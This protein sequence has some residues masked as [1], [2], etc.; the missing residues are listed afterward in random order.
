MDR[1]VWVMFTYRK[2]I[3]TIFFAF[4]VLMG[5]NALKLRMDSGFEK[6]MP[7]QHDYIKTLMAYQDDFGSGN[8]IIVALLQ[9]EGDIFTPAFFKA[10]Q[11]AT[12]EIFFLP[13]VA[14]SSVTSLFTPNVIYIEV[15]EDG[16]AGGNVIPAE[17]QPT[18]EWMPVV[19]ANV[20]KSGRLG[21]LVAN[22][23]SGALIR[24]ELIERDPTTGA[25][26]DYRK[27]AE[28]LEEKIRGRF[29]GNG[30]DVSIIGFAKS[31]GDI[32]KGAGDVVIFFGI[33]LVITGI[34]LW[35]YTRSFVLSLLP[36]LVSLV[37]VIGLLG[38]L[39]LLG[40]GLDP[41]SIL[42]PFLVF[43][44]GVSH[45]VQMVSGWMGE[46]MYG[47]DA[48][49]HGQPVVPALERPRGV[50]AMEAAQRTFRRLLVPGA[51]AVITTSVSFATILLIDIQ[52][53]RETAITASVGMAIML[54]T[55][56]ILLP[57]LL[58]YVRIH[59][60][61]A[62]RERHRS[63]EMRRDALWRFLARATDTGPSLA[64]LA[65][66]TLIALWGFHEGKQMK[67]G[68]LHAGIPELR[69]NARYNIDSR[70]IED[71]F[72]I[73]VDKLSVIVEAPEN[74]C[75]DYDIMKEIDRF[76]WYLQGL[77][78]V[79]SVDSLAR[80]IK[81]I[82]AANNEGNPRWFDLSR[83][84]NNQASALHDLER[85]GGD[86]Y[87]NASCSAM[88]VNIY[89]VDHK[90][91]TIDA[92]IKG[93]QQFESRLPEEKF[94]LR[95]AAGNVGI[96]GATNQTVAAAERPMLGWVYG[97]TIVLALLAFRSV[98]GTLCIVIP[99]AVVSVLGNAMMALLGIGLKVNTLPMMALGVG[100][101]V[102]Y[103]IY[104]YSAMSG[105]V[106]AGDTLREAYY[107]A[108]RLTGKAVIFI[109]MT[110]GAGVA[111]WIFAS[112]KFQEDMGIL[113]T[114][115]FLTNMLGAILILPALARWLVP[116]AAQ[117]KRG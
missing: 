5:I 58:S 80:S 76:A 83:D 82:I 54:L 21:E 92:I 40:Y 33:T 79:H 106:Q 26:L 10:L 17:F 36:P 64:I 46:V 42:V 74:A 11:S 67:I 110:L 93:V 9:R 22:D 44:I 16:F 98:A 30:I 13:G 32:A 23:F 86:E 48:D 102:D 66:T 18:E 24:A 15:I 77:P 45:G 100:V 37:A 3:L 1:I 27:I 41:M 61:D 113:L 75:V 62:Y 68:D 107:K 99:L 104:I 71:K 116:A 114:F 39:D 2:T 105:Y 47:G 59:K 6:L 112:L 117:A 50:D 8:Q 43:A 85:G 72:S 101:G 38:A 35:L 95:L 89:T 29:E 20:I 96:I 14:R 65:V 91:E 53:V 103:A 84:P 31:T 57:I 94:R 52:I 19:K 88:P 60:L 109:G 78:G 49:A 108:M 34:L 7:L 73:G 28:D 87:M 69:E 25:P 111:T 70:V 55:K 4:T 51:L 63:A 56:M 115:L 97:V 12:D 81:L 90:A